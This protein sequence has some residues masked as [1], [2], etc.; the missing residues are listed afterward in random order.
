MP[1]SCIC[2]LTKLFLLS[3]LNQAPHSHSTFS[4]PGAPATP[5][6][7]CCCHVL[8]RNAIVNLPAWHAVPFSFTGGRNVQLFLISGHGILL[9]SD[10]WGIQH[11]LPSTR[12]QLLWWM[13]AEHLRT[14]PSAA[15]RPRA[16]ATRHGLHRRGCH[17]GSFPVMARLSPLPPSQGGTPQPQLPEHFPSNRGACQ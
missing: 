7:D 2:I 16:A 10:T 5:G 4:K 3:L 12:R 14:W 17:L 13:S 6:S 15:R 11:H 1:P 8:L 9:D